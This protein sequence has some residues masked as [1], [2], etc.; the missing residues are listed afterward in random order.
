MDAVWDSR[1]DGAGRREVV[2]FGDQSTGGGNFGSK[3]LTNGDF[4]A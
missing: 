1:S 3:T 4:L 2:G